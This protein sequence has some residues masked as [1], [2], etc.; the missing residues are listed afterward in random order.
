M[1][2]IGEFW[3]EMDIFLFIGI[4]MGFRVVVSEGDYIES[5]WIE[6]NVGLGIKVKYRYRATLGGYL[7][8]RVYRVILISL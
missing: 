7:N 8:I 6:R 2:F 1:E 3:L 5:D 4:K